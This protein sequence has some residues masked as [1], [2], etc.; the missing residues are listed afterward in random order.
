MIIHCSTRCHGGSIPCLHVCVL[1][2]RKILVLQRSLME[3][4]ITVYKL[5]VCAEKSGHLG[6][7]NVIFW[8]TDLV[9]LYSSFEEE[10][11]IV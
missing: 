8:F 4:T 2:C 10:L 7:T 1:V 11:I 3:C 9:G 5:E 6:Q